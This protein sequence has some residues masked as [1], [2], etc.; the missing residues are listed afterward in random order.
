MPRILQF[1]RG[2]AASK[3]A[4]QDGQ[5]YLEKDTNTFVIKNDA[6]ELRLSDQS[7]SISALQEGLNTTNGTVGTLSTNVA[8]L[9]GQVST[10]QTNVSGVTGRVD[11]LETNVTNVTSRVGTVES[12]VSSLQS[13]VAGINSMQVATGTMTTSWSASGGQYVQ[14][15]TISGITANDYPQ[16]IPQWTGNK[17]NEQTAWNLLTDVQSFAGYVTLYASARPT[18]AVNFAVIF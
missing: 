1:L 2:A 5:G 17:A 18:T 4:L 13:Q 15:V 14:N 11:T 9:N 8:T 6:S 16:L 10:L 7:S 3:P 12:S